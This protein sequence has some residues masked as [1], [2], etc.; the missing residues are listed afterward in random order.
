MILS[1][2][3]VSGI[4][5]QKNDHLF[6]TLRDSFLDKKIIQQHAGSGTVLIYSLNK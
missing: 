2:Q 3:T 1:F 4:L 6:L 5:N